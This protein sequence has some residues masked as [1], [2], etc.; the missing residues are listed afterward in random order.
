M[1]AS[2]SGVRTAP[3]LLA[4]SADAI[5]DS[6]PLPFPVLAKPNCEGSSK[7]ITGD[8]I[9]RDIAHLRERIAAL[10]DSY[11]HAAIV[12]SFLPGR[13]FTIPILGTGNGARVFGDVI[14]VTLPGGTGGVYGNEI[15]FDPYNPYSIAE[16]TA[17][18][19]RAEI[20]GLS[21][22]AY[23]AVGC[24]DFGRVDVRLDSDGRPN[25]LEINPLPALSREDAFFLAARHKGLSY[26]QM[27]GTILD[28]AL[29]RL[30]MKER[31]HE[32]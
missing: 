16:D 27:I 7:G 4:E 2:H 24:R 15:V 25:F 28:E 14:A 5:L 9:S 3:F 11:G 12:E 10:T 6:F 23:R 20:A 13:E 1:V 30:G 31:K 22:A 29:V 26:T 21:L 8:S 18:E 19:L 32:D 17:P